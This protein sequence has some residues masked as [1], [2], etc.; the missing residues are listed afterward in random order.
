M[1][2]EEIHP[3]AEARRGRAMFNFRK[4]SDLRIISLPANIRQNVLTLFEGR[5]G[6]SKDN[7]AKS[8][9]A[10]GSIFDEHI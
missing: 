9:I 4:L 5:G 2:E 7:F 8:F 1:I 10:I 6:K 3:C